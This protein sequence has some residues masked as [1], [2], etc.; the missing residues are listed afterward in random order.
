[1]RAFTGGQSVADFEPR[2]PAAE[3]VGR[4]CEFLYRELQS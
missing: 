1:V 3:E 4:L 2:G